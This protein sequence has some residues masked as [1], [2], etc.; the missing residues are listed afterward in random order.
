MTRAKLTDEFMRIAKEMLNSSNTLKNKLPLSN[1]V[2]DDLKSYI[3]LAKTDFNDALADCE[4]PIEQALALAFIHSGI[5]YFTH[6]TDRKIELVI[7]KQATLNA[8][9]NKYRT[10]FLISVFYKTRKGNILKMFAIECDGHDYHEKTKKQVAYN[11]QRERDLK[12]A[13]YE[14][15]RFSGSE[16]YKDARGCVQDLMKIIF[17]EYIRLE[18]E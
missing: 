16:I 9:G 13:G 4:S 14:V 12:A 7:T 1:W 10:D 15:V 5:H 11:N 6:F 3:N 8:C 18:C 2:E 17:N